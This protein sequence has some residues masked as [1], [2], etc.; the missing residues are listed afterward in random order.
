MYI[1][2]KIWI[3]KGQRRIYLL[4]QMA[5]RHGLIAGA[6]GTGKTVTLKVLAESFSDC[7]VPVFLSDIKGDL[8]G[9]ALKGAQNPKVN[10]RVTTLGVENFS[11]KEYPVCF[12]DLYGEH[13][14]PVRTTISEMGSLLLS[15][16]LGLNET[17]TGVLSIVF[18]IADDNGLLL[19]DFK[20]LRAMIQYVGDN[21]K[22][23]TLKYGTITTQSVG[24]ILRSLITLE[25]QGGAH[26]FGEPD[27]QISDWIRTSPDGRG[28]IN[29]LHSVRLFHNPALYYTFLLWLL[30]EL[31]ESLPEVGDLKKP[32]MVFF[33]D[34]AHLLFDNAPKVLLQKI[35]QVVRLI[36]SK[37]V[38]IYFITQSPTDL[39]DEVLG[40]L[41]NRVQHAL[42]AFT[43]KD[44]KLVK[45]AAQTFRQNPN[46]DVETVIT[47]LG[48]GE[49]LLSFLDE[50][51]R[52]G[53]VERGLIL[54]PQSLFGGIEEEERKR[55]ISTSP[56]GAKYDREIDNESA[57]EVLDRMKQENLEEDQ[58]RELEDRK[59]RME[60]EQRRVQGSSRKAS[61]GYKRPSLFE[62][63]AGSMVSS[64]GREIGRTLIRG[65]LGS[66]K[67]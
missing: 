62:K 20:D 43:P 33:F 2:D 36:R 45:G 24:A 31:F 60:K 15:R 25:D 67:K 51:G 23:F 56:M 46:L 66:L 35:E 12:W 32:K 61:S 29:I 8:S 27:L 7:G 37:G 44:K 50:E 34:E 17:Q 41:G 54:P 28:V 42:R 26:F 49:A 57:Y 39:P 9:L 1:D 18:R 16:L 65:I 58:R 40:Q 11:Y 64:I 5:N 13:G 21:A 38:G 48:T 55:I 22:D 52:P 30:S 63:A 19:I 3:S 59:E 4:P 47:D 53:I 6:T 14:H 10:E